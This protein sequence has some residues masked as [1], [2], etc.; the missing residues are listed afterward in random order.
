M[1]VLKKEGGGGTEA[2]LALFPLSIYLA[3]AFWIQTWD[4]THGSIYVTTSVLSCLCIARVYIHM[5]VIYLYLHTSLVQSDSFRILLC[6]ATL[7][8]FVIEAVSDWNSRVIEARD[9]WSS[10][11]LKLWVEES[12]SDWSSSCVIVAACVSVIWI[13][14]FGWER[15]WERRKS[16]AQFCTVLSDEV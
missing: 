12:T 5:Y 13:W 4:A 7:I 8:W 2:R 15:E 11:W 1:R 3:K 16:E 10:E 14:V 9:D 6:Q